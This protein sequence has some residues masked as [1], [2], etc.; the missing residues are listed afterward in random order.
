MT[1]LSLDKGPLRRVAFVAGNLLTLLAIAAV[2]VS[3]VRTSLIDGE[4]EIYRQTEMLARF[5]AMAQQKPNA[6]AADQV[7]LTADLFQS[8]PNEGVAAANLQARLKALSEAAGARVRL[9]QGLPARSEGMLRYIGAKLE[10]FGPLPA[11]HRAIQAVESAKP[12]LFVTNSTLKL[13]PMAAR[14]GNT[15]EPTIEAQLDISGA[16]RPEGTR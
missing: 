11:V 14:S 7:A 10:I 8:G 9:V 4:A 16:F 12:F 1:L 13:S 5:K 3:P 15:A 6:P 2:I